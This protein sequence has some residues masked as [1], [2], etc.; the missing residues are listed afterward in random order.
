MQR[1]KVIRFNYVGALKKNEPFIC[2]IENKEEVRIGVGTK[3]FL[4]IQ[5]NALSFSGGMPSV[6]NIQGMSS[7]MK[8]GGMLQDLPF[9]LSIMPVT[10]FNPLPKQV[11]DPPFKAMIDIFRQMSALTSSMVI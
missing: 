5:D 11:F 7:S 8:Y 4:S 1:K 3:S 10:P 9:P 6:I 2:L